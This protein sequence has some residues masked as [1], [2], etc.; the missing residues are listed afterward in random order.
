ML[1]AHKSF[2][3]SKTIFDLC[4]IFFFSCS[5]QSNTTKEV[6]ETI[7]NIQPKDTGGGAGETREAVVYRMAKDMMS[8]LPKNYSPH[9][10][11]DETIFNCISD[12][13]TNFLELLNS[14]FH[15]CHVVKY[16]HFFSA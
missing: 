1:N 10:V 9:E 6:L 14:I 8:K 12:T 7:L 3:Y 15:S 13:V 4:I 2:L 16:L 11:N 5:Y